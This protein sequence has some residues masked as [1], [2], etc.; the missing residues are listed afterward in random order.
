M[1]D[2]LKKQHE[3]LKLKK[4]EWDRKTGDVLIKH[5]AEKKEHNLEIMNLTKQIEELKT[6]ESG[7]GKKVLLFYSFKHN[8]SVSDYKI[9]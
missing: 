3:D 2:A 9:L 1:A 6:Q 7:I 8:V 4:R 5:N